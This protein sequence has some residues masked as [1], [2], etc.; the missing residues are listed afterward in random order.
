MSVE[1]QKFYPGEE[2]TPQDVLLLA[3]EYRLAAEFLL[4]T[5]RRKSPLSRMPFRLMAIHAVELYLDAFLRA[6]GHTAAELRR[7]PHNFAARSELA[8]KAGLNLRKRTVKHLGTLTTTR[9]YLVA[10]YGAE[11]VVP[12]SPLNR[13]S[14]T[15]Q[16]VANKVELDIGK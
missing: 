9:E 13:L 4:P 5:G 15:L 3:R 8:L 16:D 6:R 12:M 14:A 11:Q 7:R 10:R 1:G 2:A